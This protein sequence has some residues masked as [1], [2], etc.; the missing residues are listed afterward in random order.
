MRNG[1]FANLSKPKAASRRPDAER[2]RKLEHMS[3]ARILS[4]ASRQQARHRADIRVRVAIVEDSIAR[5]IHARLNDLSTGGANILFPVEIAEGA[6]ALIGVPLPESAM[7]ARPKTSLRNDSILWFRSR[8]R[9]RSGFR[10]GFQF[11]D[12]SNEQKLMLRH[13]C[14]SLPV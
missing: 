4:K 13:L 12:V 11:V 3:T 6:T 1:R 2:P 7:P 5:I 10:F 9:H 14:H 8:L